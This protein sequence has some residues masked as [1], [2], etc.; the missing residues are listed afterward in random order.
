[1][2]IINGGGLGTVI[3]SDCCPTNFTLDGFT[4]TGGNGEYGS[5]I[6]GINTYTMSNST[7]KNLIFTGNEYGN[8]IHASPFSNTFE[9]V[10]I[11]RNSNGTS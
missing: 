1:M 11:V 5:S 7:F 10:A 3:K 6:S 9:N 2:T 8:I 4:I